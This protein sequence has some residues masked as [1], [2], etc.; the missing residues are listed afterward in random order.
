[1]STVE[2]LIAGLRD[3]DA[4][5]WRPRVIYLNDYDFNL[6]TIHLDHHDGKTWFRGCEVRRLPGA[7]R[8]P[9]AHSPEWED[10]L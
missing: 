10:V 4:R 1:M 9:D 5:G 8:L 6:M 3:A 2:N 7:P